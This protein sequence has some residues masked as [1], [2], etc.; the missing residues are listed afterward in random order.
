MDDRVS[1]SSPIKADLANV[2]RNTGTVG[3]VSTVRQYKKFSGTDGEFFWTV[4]IQALKCVS[5][6]GTENDPIVAEILDR[7][8]STNLSRSAEYFED[9]DRGAC[10]KPQDTSRLLLFLRV[11]VAEGPTRSDFALAP[12]V[13]FVSTDLFPPKQGSQVDRCGRSSIISACRGGIAISHRAL[14][15]FPGVL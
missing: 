15:G 10:I 4:G 6:T 8:V 11:F 14:A 1:R 13:L 7:F 5:A 9:P 3:K 12:P 2:P